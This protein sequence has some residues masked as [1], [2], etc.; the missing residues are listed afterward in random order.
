MQP[1]VRLISARRP[2]RRARQMM[3][4]GMLLI[5]VIALMLIPGWNDPTLTWRG[6]A[7]YAFTKYA[8]VPVWVFLAW[9]QMW[10]VMQWFLSTGRLGLLY[11]FSRRGRTY[12]ASWWGRIG[13][14]WRRVECLGSV[15][16]VFRPALPAGNETSRV[17]QHHWVVVTSAGRTRKFRALAPVQLGSGARAG[18]WLKSQGIRVKV[19][20]PSASG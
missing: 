20:D 3:R 9:L 4:L 16:I 5:P 13:I 14:A 19:V 1:A 8:R 7:N 10:F 2:P 11:G 15:K 17:V 12:L 6:Y 18:E